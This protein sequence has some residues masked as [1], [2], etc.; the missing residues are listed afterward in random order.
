MLSWKLQTYRHLT[1]KKKKKKH[2]LKKIQVFNFVMFLYETLF[3]V[4]S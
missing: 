1:E 4:F 3:C 2:G